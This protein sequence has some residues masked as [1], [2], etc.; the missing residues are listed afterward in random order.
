MANFSYKSSQDYLLSH[1]N[2]LIKNNFIIGISLVI[3]ALK[4]HVTN[5]GGAGLIPGQGTK[6]PQAMWYS[7]K[8]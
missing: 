6:I 3:Q 5:A 2:I 8:I 4:L 1:R 7:Q